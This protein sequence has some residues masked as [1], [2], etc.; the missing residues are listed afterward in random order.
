MPGGNSYRFEWPRNGAG[1]LHKP[2]DQQRKSY[3]RIGQRM[4][5]QRLLN[6]AW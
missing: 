2:P 4:L 6:L 5:E 1:N 3:T